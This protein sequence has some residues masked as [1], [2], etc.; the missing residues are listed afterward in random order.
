MTLTHA[1]DTR[2][3]APGMVLVVAGEVVRVN[4]VDYDAAYLVL[5]RP[6]WWRL[7]RWV[8]GWRR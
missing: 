7:W 5:H 2:H 4:R 3:F 6:L 8:T 1:V